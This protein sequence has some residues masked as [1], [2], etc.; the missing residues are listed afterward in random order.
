MTSSLPVPQR[1][2]L[3]TRPKTSS[4]QIDCQAHPGC[5]LHTS[6]YCHLE[7]YCPFHQWHHSDPIR[8][9]PT[10]QSTLQAAI[11][12]KLRSAWGSFLPAAWRHKLWALLL[13]DLLPF[14]LVIGVAVALEGE[15]LGAMT[16]AQARIVP[17]LLPGRAP[18][19]LRGPGGR[20]ELLQRSGHRIPPPRRWLARRT[21][22]CAVCF[23][24][25]A[26]GGQR[27]R[28]IEHSVGDGWT[29]C[30]GVLCWELIKRWSGLL[31][32]SELTGY[33]A[34]HNTCMCTARRIIL[35]ISSSCLF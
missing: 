1:L 4:R 5:L 15:L 35:R 8:R 9:Q 23:S 11:H 24:V 21:S 20:D 31:H 29:C 2:M 13:L 6:G 12:P 10:L 30:G 27:S 17:G 18:L 32:E 33:D 3:A 28:F 14:E 16:A 26:D 34:C 19:A 7:A 25:A 22:R